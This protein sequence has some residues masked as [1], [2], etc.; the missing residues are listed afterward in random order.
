MIYEGMKQRTDSPLL[1]Q[2]Q[3][4]QLIKKNTLQKLMLLLTALVQIFYL[5]ATAIACTSFLVSDDNRP[6]M[7]KSYD[8]D[9]GHGMVV[10]NQR[11]MKKIGLAAGATDRPPTWTAQYGSITFN[12]YGREF[13][14]GGI[15]GHRAVSK[16][17]LLIKFMIFF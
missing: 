11:G 12:Q 8:W 6:V 1:H 9:M 3:I 10:V 14:V 5:H 2:E 17:Y 4:D 7:G 16:L 15:N 13:P